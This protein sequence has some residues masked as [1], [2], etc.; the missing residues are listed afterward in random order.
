MKT[1]WINKFWI[2]YT[3]RIGTSNENWKIAEIRETRVL[4]NNLHTREKSES[5]NNVFKINAGA[6]GL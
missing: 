1:R 3:T 2:L 4:L 5:E 6:F